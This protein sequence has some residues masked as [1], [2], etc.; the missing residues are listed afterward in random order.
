MTAAVHSGCAPSRP[1]RTLNGG[2]LFQS[3]GS[4]IPRAANKV[5]PARLAGCGR[6]PTRRR[7]CRAA[8]RRLSSRPATHIGAAQRVYTAPQPGRCVPA[9]AGTVVR[10]QRTRPFALDTR[11]APVKTQRRKGD[12]FNAACPQ[13]DRAAPVAHT[14][15]HTHTYTHQVGSSAPGQTPLSPTLCLGCT[16]AAAAARAAQRGSAGAGRVKVHVKAGPPGRGAG[17]YEIAVCRHP[18]SVVMACF[19]VPSTC[20]HAVLPAASKG[21]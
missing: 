4:R 3:A 15:A 7:R 14:N 8:R 9:H 20:A 12:A 19:N 2:G 21:A 10:Q 17:E 6:T 16:A 5:W 11:P 18:H 1:D 13:R